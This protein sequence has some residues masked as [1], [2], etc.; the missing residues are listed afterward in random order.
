[1][2]S[3]LIKDLLRPPQKGSLV[4]GAGSIL[5]LEITDNSLER[6]YFI[7]RRINLAISG[8]FVH[9]RC[10]KSS[11]VL[12][13]LRRVFDNDMVSSWRTPKYFM[14]RFLFRWVNLIYECDSFQSK[15]GR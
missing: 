14:A 3:R 5:E 1:M 9:V 11:V 6:Y 4:V 2:L 15:S 13:L 12:R 7:E 10:L 8:F